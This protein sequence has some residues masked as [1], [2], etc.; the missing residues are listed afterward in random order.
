MEIG[1][2]TDECDGITSISFSADGGLMA[3]AGSDGVISI[4]D[5]E[6]WVSISCLPVKNDTTS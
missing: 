5:C 1:I 6:S 3:A 4:I 2:D